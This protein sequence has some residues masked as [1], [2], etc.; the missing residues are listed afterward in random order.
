MVLQIDED[1]LPPLPGTGLC[2]CGAAYFYVRAARGGGTSTAGAAGGASRSWSGRL[3]RLLQSPPSRGEDD[4]G[5][6]GRGALLCGG[7]HGLVLFPSRRVGGDDETCATAVP[8]RRHRRVRPWRSGRRKLP[9]LAFAVTAC[10]TPHFGGSRSCALANEH[11]VCSTK[12]TQG[13]LG[14]LPDGPSDDRIGQL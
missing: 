1:T 7:R 2:S 10:G 9:F 4:F 3:A 14:C 5:A 6:R 11:E 12:A 8:A 13:D